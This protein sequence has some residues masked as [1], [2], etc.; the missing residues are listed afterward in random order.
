MNCCELTEKILIQ[1]LSQTVF[2][3][4]RQEEQPVFCQKEWWTTASGDI[5]LLDTDV[6]YRSGN[7]VV[8]SAQSYL[9]QSMFE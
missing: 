4:K 1:Y 3:E 6:K 2:Q 7:L 9:A 8:L 5:I